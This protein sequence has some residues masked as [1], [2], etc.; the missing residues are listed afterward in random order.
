MLCSIL[1]LL[2]STGNQLETLLRR[3]PLLI[4]SSILLHCLLPCPL[5]LLK[6]L[7][8]LRVHVLHH[9]ISLPLLEAET[10]PLM[11]IILVICPKIVS[12]LYNS[13]LGV[14]ESLTGPCG[15]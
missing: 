2:L 7:D 9:C 13:I 6:V 1:S 4:T 14:Q 8:L 3:V 15:T 5:V 12:I 10:D 11:A